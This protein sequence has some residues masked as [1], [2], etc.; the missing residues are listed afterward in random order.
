MLL[1]EE[2]PDRLPFDAA[3]VQRTHAL[4]PR[5]HER[6]LVGGT[7]GRC[8]RQQLRE[9]GRL[10]QRAAVEHAVTSRPHAIT[11]DGVATDAEVPGDPTIGLA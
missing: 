7:L 5:L 10:G 2:L 3:L 11:G 8:R 6:L 4:A 1:D 9:R